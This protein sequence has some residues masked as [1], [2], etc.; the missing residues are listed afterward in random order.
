MEFIEQLI[1][2]LKEAPD[3]A[4]WVV[5][6]IF[7]YK[8]LVVGSIYG[9]LKYLANKLHDVIVFKKIEYVE[10][11]VFRD[12]FYDKNLDIVLVNNETRD[13]MLYLLELIHKEFPNIINSEYLHQ[14][15]VD[16]AIDCIR[17]KNS[18]SDKR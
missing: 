5:A 6:I 1:D 10:K 4:I 11:E 7:A 15:Q 14:S 8:A 3:L 17:S 2:V 9:V 18:N 12:F 13:K 16:E